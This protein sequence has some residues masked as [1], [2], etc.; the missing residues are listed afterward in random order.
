L[1]QK[2]PAVAGQMIRIT[3]QSA[4]KGKEGL[5]EGVQGKEGGSFRRAGFQ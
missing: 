1:S 4:K 5:V 3:P 2:G